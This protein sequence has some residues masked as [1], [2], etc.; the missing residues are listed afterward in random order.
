MAISDF[1][2]LSRTNR[3]S[4]EH[5]IDTLEHCLD[6]AHFR[7]YPFKV[8]YQFN[9]RGLRDYE[10]PE[11]L[12]SATWCIGDSAT[13]GIGAPFEHSWPAVLENKTKLRTVNISMDGVSNNWIARRAVEIITEIAPKN[14][15]IVW[16]FVERREIDLDIAI[17]TE[18]MKFYP[19]IKDPSWPDVE[20]SK[21]P[22]IIRKEI[23]ENFCSTGHLYVS[24]DLGQLCA[25][26][27][28]DAD[29][30]IQ[31]PDLDDHEENFFQCYNAVIDA[32]TDTNVIQAF[33]PGFA[34]NPAVYLE[35]CKSNRNMLGEIVQL[36]RARDGHHF[37]ILTSQ[38]FAEQVVPLLKKR[39][40]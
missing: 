5:G 1:A 9:S 25:R 15:I 32:A 4:L 21:L 33:V 16:S 30:I 8:D 29:R 2:I 3:Y 10:W 17:Q 24:D 23:A 37:D 6:K 34:E 13:T 27:S 7:T 26:S 12:S 36:D 22:L 14:L 19:S 39:Q 28:I 35:P 20:F 40:I 31:R 18:W 11:N 38:R